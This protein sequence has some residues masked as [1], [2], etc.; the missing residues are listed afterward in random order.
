M[1]TVTITATQGK[2]EDKAEFSGEYEMPVDCEEMIESWGEQK[3]FDLAKKGE[4]INIQANLRRPSDRKTT[5]CYETYKR[6]LEMDMSDE[7]AR[8]ASQYNGNEDGS[9]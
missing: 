6:L 1:E 4:I 5:S 3:V 9:S 2:G 7:D 8:K